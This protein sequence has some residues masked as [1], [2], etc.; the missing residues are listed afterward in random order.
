VSAAVTDGPPRRVLEVARLG[1]IDLLVADL[2][3]A[4]LSRIL[5]AKLGWEESQVAAYLERLDSITADHPTAPE[6]AEAVTGDPSDD[7]I[8]A[9]AIAVEADVLVTGDRKHLLPLGGVGALRIL[10]PQTLLAEL[11]G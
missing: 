3:R 1:A 7:R 11:R 9:C 8:L 6:E 10:Q 2:V 4:E 5:V